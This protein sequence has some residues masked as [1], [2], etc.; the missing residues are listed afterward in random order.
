MRIPTVLIL[1]LALTACKSDDDGDGFNSEEDCDDLSDA[2]HPGATEVCDSVD[3]NCDGQVDEGLG[4]VWYRDLDQDGFGD[5]ATSESACDA[6]EGYV[7]N[8]DDC[9]DDDAAFHP[10]ASET[11]CEDPNDYN[12]DGSTGFA[13]ADSDGYPACADCDDSN[14][15]ANEASA[16][17]CDGLD[18]DCDGL[19]DYE[20]EDASTF[21][22]DYDG[23][24]FGSADYPLEECGD[25]APVGYVTNALDCD[26]LAAGTYPE[27]DEICDEADNDCDG[28]VDEDALDALYY[29]ADLD[30][31]GYGDPGAE[32]RSCTAD[33]AGVS[34]NALDCDDGDDGINPD[35][36]EICNT[37]MDDDCDGS[38]FP[39]T[40]DLSSETAGPD[41]SLYGINAS[42]TLGYGMDGAVDINNDGQDDL[43]VS[44]PYNDAGG[45]DAGAA[46]V[47]YGPVSAGPFV[48]DEVSGGTM[49]GFIVTG[50]ASEGRFGSTVVALDDVDG[51]G[52]S[53]FFIGAERATDSRASSG[54]GYLFLGSS[55]GTVDQ[56]ADDADQ[57]WEGETAYDY[58]GYGGV[59]AGDVDDDGLSD[60]MVSATGDDDGAGN[61]GA[62]YLFY[63]ADVVGG[64]T[65]SQASS[66][67]AKIYEE[68]SSIKIGEV[69]TMAGVYNLDGDG[70]DDIVIAARIS[71][72][73]G[74]NQAGDVHLIQGPVDGLVSLE[75]S[76]G[77]IYGD[78]AKDRLGSTVAWA[79]DVDGDGYDD[80][81]AE[82]ELESSAAD[83]AGAVYIILGGSDLSIYAGVNVGTV[84]WAKFEGEDSGDRVGSSLLGGIDVN[85]DG[86]DDIV[87]GAEQ[88]G[89]TNQGKVYA[90]M[91]PLTTG[92]HSVSSADAILEDDSNSDY[93]GS[94]L[95]NAGDA[96]G[97]GRDHIL[98][99]A[100][101][102]DSNGVDAGA[103]YLLDG[104]A[105]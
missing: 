28:E 46:Y 97:S 91:G 45:T 96:S 75:D 71:S 29:Y 30:G 40:F 105:D 52:Y 65:G 21:Y 5:A 64:G 69:D 26:D 37:G 90:I 76:A 4:S 13:D 17:I 67:T 7:D 70:Y 81:M 101:G 55:V 19:V 95:R 6:I 80:L 100:S 43:I 39:C 99:A 15:A 86:T 36:T 77:T 89:L 27:A 83:S 10:G 57:T 59:S 18:N 103:V 35:A 85:D 3:N 38:A 98:I 66:Y 84:A 63:G 20:A 51:D 44:A 9:N 34:D 56:Q 102:D 42:D 82:S 79:G 62:V 94:M 49:S 1:A 2:V 87:L 24:G 32:V 12:C 16:E 33:V 104:I 41:S 78:T 8:G 88:G 11:D 14:A 60:W 47:F 48:A 72:L 25:T 31:D 53:D 50:V 68:T 54:V 58:F 23:D 93:A 22:I 61:A 92:T 74:R 73:S